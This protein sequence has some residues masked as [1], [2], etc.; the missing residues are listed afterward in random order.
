MDGWEVSGKAEK[1]GKEP[2]W[3]TDAAVV[4]HPDED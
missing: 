4:V 2:D 1:L 3:Y